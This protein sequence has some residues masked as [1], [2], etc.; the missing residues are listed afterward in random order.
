MVERE[1]LEVAAKLLELLLGFAGEAHDDEVRKTMPGIFA[2][3]FAM[4][5]RAWPWSAGGS[6][7]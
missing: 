6:S 3:S 1:G 5:Q 4:S 2:R 7:T